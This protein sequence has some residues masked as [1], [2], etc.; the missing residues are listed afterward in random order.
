MNNWALICQGTDIL[1][2]F[3]EFLGIWVNESR[4][5]I[6]P[7]YIQAEIWRSFYHCMLGIILSR[8][9]FEIVFQKQIDFK[10][11]KIPSSYGGKKG[12]CCLFQI[13][14]LFKCFYVLF[15]SSEFLLPASNANKRNELAHEKRE[16]IVFWFVVL[17][18]CMR[19]PLFGL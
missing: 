16:L 19:S 17:Q 8:W 1:K 5:Y 7:Q 2:Y 12:Y 6:V 15:F 11:L 4:L 9:Q 10:N 18:M 13:M 3:R 14:L